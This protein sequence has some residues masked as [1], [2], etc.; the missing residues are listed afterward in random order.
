MIRLIGSSSNRAYDR[1]T[2]P[3]RQS[4]MLWERA[5]RVLPS[6][7]EKCKTHWP[8]N[9]QMA[10]NPTTAHAQ[11][12]NSHIATCVHTAI[13]QVNKLEVT[14]CTQYS[15]RHSEQIIHPHGVTGDKWILIQSLD[16]FHVLR[17]GTHVW[18]I[19]SRIHLRISVL[20][21]VNS[22]SYQYDDQLLNNNYIKQQC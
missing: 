22:H 7:E 17:K 14:I 10:S 12:A 1:R 2:E 8:W 20:F 21:S 16:S 4:R 13:L 19:Q 3:Q 9:W 18:K 6:P 15:D 11:W 5:E